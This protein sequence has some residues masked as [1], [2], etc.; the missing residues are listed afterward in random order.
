MN[1]KTLLRGFTIAAHSTPPSHRRDVA[2]MSLNREAITG[3]SGSFRIA[4]VPA[5]STTLR[6]STIHPFL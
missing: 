5:G 3:E 1:D 2:R 6:A 4:G